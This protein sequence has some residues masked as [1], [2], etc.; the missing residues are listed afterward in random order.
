MK[1]LTITTLFLSLA[2]VGCHQAADT[3]EESQMTMVT[4]STEEKTPETPSLPAE[5]FTIE[6]AETAQGLSAAKSAAKVGDKVVIKG[7]IG[8]R[9]EPFTE[10]RAV[11]VMG[12]SEELPVC[13]P[14]YC[15]T[16]WDACCEL[17]EDIVANS[18]TIQVLDETGMPL[19]VDLKGQNGLEPGAEITVSG[20]VKEVNDS[21]F[22]VNATNIATQ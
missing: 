2:L 19:K 17:K 20:E 7:Y 5:F 3:S 16:Y 8:G 11:F 21:I 4:E 14:A 15:E 10:S 12:D 1:S 9:A 18:A 6:N 22:I 13:D